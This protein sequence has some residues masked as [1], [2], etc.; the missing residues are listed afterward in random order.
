MNKGYFNTDIGKKILVIG[1]PGSGKSTFARKLSAVMK[2]PLFYLDMIWHKEDKTNV[3]REVF[4]EELEKI[5][6]RDC[7]I[8]DGNYKRTLEKILAVSDT[9]FLFDLPV[10]ECLEGVRNRIGTKREDLPWIEEEEDPEFMDYIRDF[11][12]EQMPKMSELLDRYSDRVHLIVFRSRKEADNFIEELEKQI[13][14]TK[15]SF[16]AERS[17]RKAVPEDL[18]TLMEIYAHARDYMASTGNPDQWGKNKWPPRNVVEEDIQEGKSHVLEEK[19]DI[20]AVF[21]LD[22]GY[23][24]DPCYDYIENGEWMIDTP[25]AVIHRIAVKENGKGYGARCIEA[26]YDLYGHARMDTHPDNTVM[27]HVLTKLGFSYQGIIYVKQDPDPRY[28]FEIAK[29]EDEGSGSIL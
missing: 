21:Y 28:A 26:V 1:S 4:D 29:K 3:E 27:Q 6:E 7:F 18:D 5:L 25:Y 2:L 10:E 17:I 19:G 22:Y 16:L 8:I 13:C 11:P 20:K 9:V 12:K 15:V 14:E 24:I 23:H